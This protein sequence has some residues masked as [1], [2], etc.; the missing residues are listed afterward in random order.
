M[1]LAIMLTEEEALI[2]TLVYFISFT[3]EPIDNAVH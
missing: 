1:H 2:S 3:Q